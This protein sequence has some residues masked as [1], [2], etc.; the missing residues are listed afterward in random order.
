MFI[1]LLKLKEISKEKKLAM[2]FSTVL[3]LLL[4]TLIFIL[5]FSKQYVLGFLILEY[6]VESIVDSLNFIDFKNKIHSK[7]SLFISI[8]IILLSIVTH[9][10]LLLL[11]IIPVSI[12]LSSV[13]NNKNKE[14]NEFYTFVCKEFSKQ[15]YGAIVGIILLFIVERVSRLI[16]KIELVEPTI[17]YIF[18][19]N[20]KFIAKLLD[21][22]RKDILINFIK[23]MKK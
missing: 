1:F 14:R 6:C 9:N 11:F 13:I 15:T 12:F 19:Y 8:G 23:N 16:F 7:V 4:L 22:L 10:I 2:I 3:F 17:E 5:I 20:F 21:F 18:A